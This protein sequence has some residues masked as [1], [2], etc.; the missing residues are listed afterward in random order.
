M[1]RELYAGV[2]AVKGFKKVWAGSYE[3]AIED[4]CIQK[5]IEYEEAE[6]ILK[7][8]TRAQYVATPYTGGMDEP[9][10]FFNATKIKKIPGI[11]CMWDFNGP[12]LVPLNAYK[13]ADGLLFLIEMD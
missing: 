12:K 6:R 11:N 9:T 8:T 10:I 4:I 1:A 7:Q 3:E 2:Y 5:D 13:W